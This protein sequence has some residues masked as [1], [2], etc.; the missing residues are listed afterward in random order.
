MTYTPELDRTTEYTS[1]HI[2]GWQH[3][4]NSL[5]WLADRR[6]GLSLD[7]FNVFDVREYDSFGEAKTA[8]IEMYQNGLYATTPPEPT[9]TFFNAE[10]GEKVSGTAEQLARKFKYKNTKCILRTIKEVVGIG[11]QE[12][13]RVVS[14]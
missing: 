6:F 7:N 5:H 10:T 3:W 12:G 8:L 4:Q 1:C 14:S 9:Y 13:W 11:R 2:N